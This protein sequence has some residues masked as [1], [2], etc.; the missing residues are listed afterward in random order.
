MVL[1]EI[2]YDIIQILSLPAV[3]ASYLNRISAVQ[4]QFV[5]KRLSGVLGDAVRKC[6]SCD[7]Y[8]LL[9]QLNDPFLCYTIVSDDST[10]ALGEINASLSSSS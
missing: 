5:W 6:A 2:I 1:D 8:K 9:G 3:V 7:V 4:Y 10:L